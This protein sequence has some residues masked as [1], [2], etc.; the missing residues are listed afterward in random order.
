MGVPGNF[1]GVLR[2]HEGIQP[3]LDVLYCFTNHY[4][5]YLSS[6]SFKS[7]L[8]CDSELLIVKQLLLNTG[9]AKLMLNYLFMGNRFVLSRFITG[10]GENSVTICGSRKN[11]ISLLV[12]GVSLYQVV[13]ISELS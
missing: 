6:H 5:N 8:H 10:F 2:S 11:L 7:H 1:Y 3:V 4:Y 9:V 13:I 12:W